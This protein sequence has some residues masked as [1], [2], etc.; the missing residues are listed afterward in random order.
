MLRLF[1]GY[2]PKARYLDN[3]ECEDACDGHGNE[4]SVAKMES[5]LNVVACDELRA[6]A[7][8]WADAAASDEEQLV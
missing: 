2:T 6:G 3:N 1:C 7:G 8:S 4:I 5:M